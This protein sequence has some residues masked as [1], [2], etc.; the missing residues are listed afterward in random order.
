[1][2]EELK[3]YGSSAIAEMTGGIILA[4]YEKE[5]SAHDKA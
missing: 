2:S 5:S 4:K 1:M 3:N